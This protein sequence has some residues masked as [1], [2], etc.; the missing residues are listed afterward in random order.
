MHDVKFLAEHFQFSERAI[1]RR[2]AALQTELGS[3][4]DAYLTRGKVDKYLITN[5]GLAALG[6]MLELERAG[7]TIEE[8]A[9]KV[10]EEMIDASSNGQGNGTDA[11]APEIADF[12]RADGELVAALRETIEL[13]KVQLTEKDRQIERLQDILQNRLP[14]Q[15]D[16]QAQGEF[17]LG[18]LQKTIQAQ[19]QE[20]EALRE[21]LEG[22]KTPW[23]RRLMG[24][25]RIRSAQP[26]REEPTPGPIDVGLYSSQP[27]E[28]AE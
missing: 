8:A 22:V 4:G 5:N 13:L 9:K 11:P 17:S 16:P 28:R 1:N 18:Y 7:L 26:K 24:P 27:Q 25:R 15:V 23:W 14:G 20:I 21:E 19:R 6:R 12:R 3:Q 10:R 2:L